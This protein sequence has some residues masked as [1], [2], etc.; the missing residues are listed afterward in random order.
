MRSWVEGVAGERRFGGIIDGWVGG[1]A[2]ACGWVRGWGAGWVDDWPTGWM[3]GWMDGQE[4][5][6]G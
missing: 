1:R 6:M 4:P 5:Q 3:G 2:A